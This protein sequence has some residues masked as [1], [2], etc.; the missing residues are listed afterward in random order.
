SL[1]RLVFWPPQTGGVGIGV[2]LLSYAGRLTVGVSAD[3]QLMADPRQLIEAFD[4]ELD[5]LLGRSP[6][7]SR[8]TSGAPER[9]PAKRKP[10]VRPAKP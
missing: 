2:S 4:V 7:R 5:L 10:R 6:R 8:A 1:S 3:T 9:S